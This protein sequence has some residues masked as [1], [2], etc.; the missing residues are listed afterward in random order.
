MRHY[1]YLYSDSIQ[2]NIESTD[3]VPSF[4]SDHSA[5]K[6]KLCSLQEGYWKFN[7]SLIED[8]TFFESL[9]QKYRIAG[10]TLIIL[11]M[12]RLDGNS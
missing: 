8:K 7:S 4:G 6:I 2:E 3:I 9:K 10:E 12:L 5:I 1:L 11:T